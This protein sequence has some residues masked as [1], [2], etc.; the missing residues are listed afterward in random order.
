MMSARV[1]ERNRPADL[2]I[3]HVVQGRGRPN[4]DD[5]QE[6]LAEAFLE[7]IERQA[8]FTPGADEPHNVVDEP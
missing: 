1:S 3:D 4:S 5:V 8:A 6:K 7:P 2:K